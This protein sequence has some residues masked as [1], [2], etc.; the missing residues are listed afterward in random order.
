M[1]LL[2]S[3]AKDFMFLFHFVY[4]LLNLK[5]LAKIREYAM[6]MQN[7][8]RALRHICIVFA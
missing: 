1:F 4:F 5:L 6:P 2:Q 7:N 8:K 3:L